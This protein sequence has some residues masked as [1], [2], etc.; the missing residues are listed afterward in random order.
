MDLTLFPLQFVTIHNHTNAR[1]SLSSRQILPDR[2]ELAYHI[3]EESFYYAGSGRMCR[4][5]KD[6]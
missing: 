6:W 3:R 4:K 2:P 5:V 1:Y